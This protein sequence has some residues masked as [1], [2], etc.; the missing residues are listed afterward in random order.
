MFKTLPTSDL[1]RTLSVLSVAALP[2]PILSI[3]VRIVR[4]YSALISDSSILSWPLRRT[5]YKAFCIGVHK[6]EIT[7]NIAT[8]KSRGINGVVL[9]FAREAKLGDH[10]SSLELVST[11][12]HLKSWVDFNVQT[13]EQ[14]GDGDFIAVKIT[15]AGSA[16][17]K[18]MEAFESDNLTNESITK[19]MVVLKNALFEICEAGRKK[20]IKIMLDAESSIHQRAIDWLALVSSLMLYSCSGISIDHEFRKLWQHSTLRPTHLSSIHIRCI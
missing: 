7:S 8:L 19:E 18:A 14:V 3:L 17:V 9:S 15:G 1:L 12:T 20:D 4:R 2:S 13:V 11:D 5:F 16:A 10:E 6:Q